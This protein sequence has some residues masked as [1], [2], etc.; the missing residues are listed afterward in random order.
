MCEHDNM[1]NSAHPQTLRERARDLSEMKA[2]AWLSPPLWTAPDQSRKP[3][4]QAHTQE[5]AKIKNGSIDREENCKE[6]LGTHFSSDRSIVWFTS[7]KTHKHC[8]RETTRLGL[9]SIL[10]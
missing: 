4:K 9:I 8:K 10:K 1:K 3:W 5:P 7:Q 6:A 2:G